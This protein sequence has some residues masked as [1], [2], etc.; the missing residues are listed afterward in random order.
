M[1]AIIKKIV[2]GLLGGAIGIIV[3]LGIILV[4]NLITN[5]QKHKK[6]SGN[7][8]FVYLTEFNVKAYDLANGDSNMVYGN[9][10]L[11]VHGVHYNSDSSM[12]WFD[13]SA[14]AE[15]IQLTY[16]TRIK[17][18][19]DYDTY[20]ANMIKKMRAEGINPPEKVPVAMI[21]GE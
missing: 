16:D 20:I 17:D 4:F 6:N 12:M 19:P 21:F 13:S 5:M 10:V 7:M 18:I 1:K 15:V 11:E 14:Y 3:I 9:R 8:P 2:K